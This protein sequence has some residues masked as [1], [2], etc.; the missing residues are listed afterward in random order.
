MAACRIFRRA[1]SVIRS[2]SVLL[3]LCYIYGNPALRM[4]S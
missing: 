2:G 4:R 1:L 3:M